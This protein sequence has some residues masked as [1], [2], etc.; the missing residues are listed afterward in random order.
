MTKEI[1]LCGDLEL[2]KT[3]CYRHNIQ[4]SQA[5]RSHKELK[6][7]KLAGRWY[8]K[9][10]IPIPEDVKKRFHSYKSISND[11]NFIKYKLDRGS[12][13]NAI[14]RADF[15]LNN[16]TLIVYKEDSFFKA[17]Y[18]DII[19]S[20]Y[21]EENMAYIYADGRGTYEIS[22]EELFKNKVFVECLEYDKYDIRHST[23]YC[24]G[25]F[26]TRNWTLTKEEL[27]REREFENNLK[28]A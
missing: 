12:K 22:V 21:P 19:I 15:I 17:E 5:I 26:F 1:K 16:K 11:E 8:I 14:E 20:Y 4:V 13:Y 18:E 7:R 6:M 23:V 10:N 3:W 25:K 2:I 24:G 27:D 9:K 28:K